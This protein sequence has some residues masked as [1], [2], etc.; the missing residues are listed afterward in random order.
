MLLQQADD[1]LGFAVPGKRLGGAFHQQDAPRQP[2]LDIAGGDAAHFLQVVFQ[3]CA[4][5]IALQVVVVQGEQG[6]GG[7]YYQRGGQKN[8]VTELQ[9]IIHGFLRPVRSGTSLGLVHGTGSAGKSASAIMSAWCEQS[10][11]SGDI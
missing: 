4:D 7:D 6:E 3:I 11:N 10:F 1:L 5:R 9:I 2:V 8:L